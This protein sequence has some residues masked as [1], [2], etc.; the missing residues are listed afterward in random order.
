VQI[1]IVVAINQ[2]KLFVNLSGLAL[3]INL[4]DLSGEGFLNKCISFRVSRS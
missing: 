3:N 1:L 4:D 2:V